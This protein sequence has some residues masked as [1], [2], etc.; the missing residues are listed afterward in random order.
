MA[1]APPQVEEVAPALDEEDP[2]FF[3]FKS[4]KIQSVKKGK[5]GKKASFY[6]EEEK[7]VE[8]KPD[9]VDDEWTF[10]GHHSA[11]LF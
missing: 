9:L 4:R 2:G 11:R 3:G 8:A 1:T 6:A 10:G 7:P 5:K